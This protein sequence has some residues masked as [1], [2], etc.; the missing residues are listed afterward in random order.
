MLLALHCYHDGRELGEAVATLTEAVDMLE[1]THGELG[2]NQLATVVA[3]WHA[4]RHRLARE[5]I[6]QARGVP[7]DDVGAVE[8]REDAIEPW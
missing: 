6:D 5:H 7:D 8:I 1:A 3:G 2:D 4:G